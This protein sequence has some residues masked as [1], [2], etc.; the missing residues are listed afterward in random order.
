MFSKSTI[1]LHHYLDISR[2]SMSRALPGAEVDTE[3]IE[4]SPKSL[5]CISYSHF[6][7]DQAQGNTSM[8]VSM[9]LSAASLR[10]NTDI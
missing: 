5:L 6:P 7:F 3:F 1:I 8:F 2:A 4:V 9:H 10:M